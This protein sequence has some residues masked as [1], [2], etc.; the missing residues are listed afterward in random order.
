MTR[1]VLYL[2][3]GRRMNGVRQLTQLS[4]VPVQIHTYTLAVVCLAREPG[5]HETHRI[6]PDH[7]SRSV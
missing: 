2:G 4:L 5:T 3:C 7:S 6:D 1:F